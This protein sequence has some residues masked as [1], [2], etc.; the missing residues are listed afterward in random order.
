[1]QAVKI[2]HAAGHFG[3]GESAREVAFGILLEA[4]FQAGL[5]GEAQNHEY[6]EDNNHSSLVDKWVEKYKSYACLRKAG[7]P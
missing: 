2:E 7:H 3:P 5:H 1:M 4:V 6:D